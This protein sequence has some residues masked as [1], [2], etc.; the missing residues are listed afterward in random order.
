MNPASAS[1]TYRRTAVQ[2]AS[3][4]AL[5][6]MLYDMLV[7][8]LTRAIDA[9]GDGDIEKRSE[10]IKHALL[11]LHQLEGSLD[12]EKGGEAAKGLSRFYSFIRGQILQAQIK[13][14]PEIL[15]K[16]IEVILDVRQAWQQAE[17]QGIQAAV[18]PE[19]PPM[20]KNSYAIAEDGP[21]STWSA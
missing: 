20:P 11:V 16:Q 14:E 6:V 10:H 8:D 12:M 15:R 5:V 3:P 21:T 2:N 7:G 4:V 17:T 9:I 13:V 18:N 1:L 19:P